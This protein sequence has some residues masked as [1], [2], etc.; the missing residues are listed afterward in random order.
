MSEKLTVDEVIAFLNSEEAKNQL[1]LKACRKILN[2]ITT[3]DVY[4]NLRDDE[5]K[6]LR[7]D[8]HLAGSQLTTRLRHH[9]QI[10]AFN[11]SP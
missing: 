7:D 5:L 8:L 9:A 6:V 10:G 11:F 2:A 4:A 3:S 1:T